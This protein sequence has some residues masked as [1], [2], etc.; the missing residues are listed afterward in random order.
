MT[1]MEQL[2]H[3]IY[4]FFESGNLLIKETFLNFHI[5]FLYSR[6]L[7]NIKTIQMHKYEQ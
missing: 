5:I 2:K 6:Y 3:K 7:I 4:H 1:N